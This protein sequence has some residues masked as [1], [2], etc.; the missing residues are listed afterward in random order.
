[1]AHATHR[2]R[3]QASHEPTDAA[4]GWVAHRPGRTWAWLSC[5]SRTQLAYALILM[6]ELSLGERNLRN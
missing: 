4:A 5:S 1:M 3:P 2:D 6:P